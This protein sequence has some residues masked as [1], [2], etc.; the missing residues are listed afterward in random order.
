MRWRGAKRFGC[1]LSMLFIDL[2]F[3]KNINDKHGHICGSKLLTEMGQVILR[4][5][6]SV[7]VA[8]RYG[9]DEFV[10]PHAGNRQK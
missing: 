7:D 8:C 4:G 9:G 3:F 10:V 2:D 1:D 6:R 5:I